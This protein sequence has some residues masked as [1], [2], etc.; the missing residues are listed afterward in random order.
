M[1][2]GGEMTKGME[3]LNIDKINFTTEEI[4]EEFE[5]GYEL[6]YRAFTK[7]KSSDSK[8]W[9][10]CIDFVSDPE[11]LRIAIFNNDTLK[12]PTI[13]VFIELN[14]DL[15]DELDI[16]DKKF[17]GSFFGFLYKQVFGYRGQKQVGI[18]NK[19]IRTGSYFYDNPYQIQ[20]SE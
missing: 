9:R 14:S 7:Y 8:L 15:T 12:L 19:T 3:K 18:G 10:R 1:I 20:V 16:N 13:K 5:T 17:L 11:L 6:S 2:E 4:L